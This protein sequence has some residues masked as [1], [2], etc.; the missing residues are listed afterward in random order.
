[1]ADTSDTPVNLRLG[2]VVIK[3]QDMARAVGF[4]SAVLGYTRRDREWD[5][6]FTVL[7]DPARRRVP[8]SLQ[9]ID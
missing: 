2:A 6:E 9:L 5:P 3:V 1:M 4:W 8:V 7:V